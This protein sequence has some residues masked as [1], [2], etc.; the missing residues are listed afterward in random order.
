MPVSFMKK[1]TALEQ[2]KHSEMCVIAG[3]AWESLKIKRID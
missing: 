1:E 3:T 2:S